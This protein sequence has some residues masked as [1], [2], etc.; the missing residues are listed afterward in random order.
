MDGGAWWAAVQGVAKSQT[1]L[2]NFTFMHWRRKWQPTQ[3]SCLESPRDGG[4]WWAAVYGVAQSRTRLKRLS[5]R[6][7][8]A[9]G[10]RKAIK[11]AVASGDGR[12]WLQDGMNAILCTWIHTGSHR[13]VC[14]YRK[15]LSGT[16]TICVF[17]HMYRQTLWT[18]VDKKH[19]KL[20][21]GNYIYLRVKC[22]NAY[23]LIWNASRSVPWLQ[24]PVKQLE[25]THLKSHLWSF[26]A[27]SQVFMVHLF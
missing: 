6:A 5:S 26:Q 3:C 18:L 13:C 19:V 12:G 11:A 15:S 7:G 2:S 10:W 14:I 8:K 25:N 16:L 1:R 4:A 9:N 22:N 17:L 20:Y 27:D 23:K 24:D 21:S